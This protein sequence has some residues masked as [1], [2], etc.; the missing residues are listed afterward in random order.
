MDIY[1]NISTDS[2]LGSVEQLQY[3]LYRRESLT[4]IS[5][6]LCFVVF[7]GLAVIDDK[8]HQA[9]AS[10]ATTLQLTLA[11]SKVA[12]VE[13]TFSIAP[14]ETATAPA[15]KTAPPSTPKRQPPHIMH[16][17]KSELQT[18]TLPP[19]NL[20]PSFKLEAS[21]EYSGPE[22][23]EVNSARRGA[24][25]FDNNFRRSLSSKETTR[26]NRQSLQ[27]TPT[28]SSYRHS[29]GDEMVRVGSRCA[30]IKEI[31]PGQTQWLSQPCPKT[32]NDIFKEWDKRH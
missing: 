20:A 17:A 29:S 6:L 14:T 11:P 31:A 7:I 19:L 5:S 2:Q 9:A 8:P 15:S 16:S 24:T 23:S 25:V 26:L 13:K 30:R 27:K 12:T 32:Y 28:L 22:N 1:L 3:K 21:E 10:N 18:R 4:V